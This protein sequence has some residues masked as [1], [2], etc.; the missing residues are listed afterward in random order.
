[1]GF[2]KFSHFLEQYIETLLSWVNSVLGGMDRS[3]G[4]GDCS[5]QS[6][7]ERVFS[8]LAHALPTVDENRSSIQDYFSGLLY[9]QFKVGI[10]VLKILVLHVLKV[11]LKHPETRR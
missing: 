10:V 5:Y 4:V 8:F 6:P 3:I 2:R 1:M 11:C 7:K 9:R